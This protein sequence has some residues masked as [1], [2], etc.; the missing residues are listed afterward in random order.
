MSHWA[1]FGA[2]ARDLPPKAHALMLG[3]EFTDEQVAFA[4]AIRDFAAREC[5]T[6]EQR[7]ELTAH[8]EHQHN[9]A[10]YERIAALGWV[11]VAMPEEYGGGGMGAVD[12]CIMLEESHCGDLP[13]GAIR[14]SLIVAGNYERAGSREQQARMIRDVCCGRVQAIAM[15]EPEAG[16]DVA[17]VRCKAE[18]VDGGFLVNGQK[19]WCSNAHLA[20]N[21]LL[22]CRTS[23]GEKKQFGLTMLEVPTATEGMEL[24]AIETMNGKDTNDVFFADCFVAEQ[25]LIGEEDQAWGPLVGGLNI[26]RLIVAA[27][28]LGVARR[29]LNVALAYIKE[30]K[31]FGQAIGSFQVIKHRFAEL[32]TELE[33]CELLVY[34]VARKVDQD[35]TQMLPREASMTKLKVTEVARELTLACVQ[36]MGGYG[37]AKEYEVERLARQSIGAAIYGGT[38]EI[39]R[40]IIGRTYGL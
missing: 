13:I 9:Q 3:H 37:Y 18:R 15:S 29:A 33:C 32:A 22:I 34:A 36:M 40:D 16:S 39:Q 10:L 2:V 21:L 6:P 28:Q 11:G 4:E 8:G 23:T 31:Q 24:V 20:D 5:G 1:A 38:N 30:R 17:N 12:Q 14:S 27:A 35:P 7:Q 25:N 26:E 19:T